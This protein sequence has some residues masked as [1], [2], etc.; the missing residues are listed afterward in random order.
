[1]IISKKTPKERVLELGKVCDM[2]NHCCSFTT[3][4]L[5]EDD[6][7]IIAEHL[8][9]SE[10][11]LKEKFLNEVTMFNT[12]V[13]RPKSLKTD[14]PHGPCVFLDK[15]IGCKIHEVKPLHCK[16]YTCQPHGFE[17]TQWFYLNYLVNPKDPQSIREYAMFLQSNK[18][19]PGG[20]LKE[21]VPDARERERILNYE[22]FRQ[23]K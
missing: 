2:S 12:K 22:V 23:E 9:I 14:K 18:P 21:L 1:M 11:E 13:L 4:F 19:I 15:E 5:A 20:E 6:A 8:N 3:G 16:L 7:K 10:E 17:L